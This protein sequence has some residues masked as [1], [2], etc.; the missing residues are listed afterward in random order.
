MGLRL[1][2]HPTHTSPP[3][4]GILR[5][6]LVWIGVMAVILAGCT[7][8]PAAPSFPTPIPGGL[9]VDPAQV[10]GAISPYVY[11]ANHGPWAVITTATQPLAEAA[12]VT[13]LRFPG[14]NWGD[15]HNLRSSHIDPFISLA[16]SMGAVPSI[17]V[18]L[19]GGTPEQAADLV[20]YVNLEKGYQ[21]RYW[22]I[23]NEPQYYEGYDTARFNTEWRAIAQAMQAVDP[24][25]LLLGPEVT[26]WTGDPASNPKDEAGRGWVEEFLRA[27]GDL[28]DIVTIHRYPFPALG[29]DAPTIDDLRL[30]S[31]EWDRILPALR[32][33]IQEITGH[34]LPVAVTEVNSNWSNASGSDATPDSLYNAIWWADALGRMITQRVEIVTFFSLQSNPS[35]GGYG[36]LARSEPRPTYFTYQMYQHFGTTLVESSSGDEAVSIYASLHEDGRLAVLL[37]N[38]G[39]EEKSLPLQIST[40]YALQEGWLLDESHPAEPIAVPAWQNGAPVTLPGASVTVFILTAAVTK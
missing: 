1:Q 9:Y 11:G 34:E 20:R 19:E 36:L 5:L 14:G 37:V 16:A 29:G 12:G 23:G 21:V 10:V 28:V 4:G 2:K 6:A 26:Q 30:N 35:T 38:L 31:P 24:T 18:R 3:P 15:L 22:S 8:T 33:T 17:S 13:F 32:A 27:N 39:A 25:I 40:E 7:P